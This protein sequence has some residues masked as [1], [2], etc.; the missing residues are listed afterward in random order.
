MISQIQNVKSL[1][2]LIR[3]H[4][5]QTLGYTQIPIGKLPLPSYSYHLINL[6]L[7]IPKTSTAQEGLSLPYPKLRC[8][9]LD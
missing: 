8:F 7:S 4:F 1:K 2:H 6:Q 5:S 3:P 9:H